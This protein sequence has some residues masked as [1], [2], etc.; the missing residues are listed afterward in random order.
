MT[1]NIRYKQA[2]KEALWAFG[3]TILY[4]V[5]WCICAYGLPNTKGFL[6]FPL[7]FEF[8][9]L[10]LPLLFTFI[11]YVCIKCVFRDIDLEG[12]QDEL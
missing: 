4:M 9:C 5:G 6:D 7:W 3:L 11:V 2:T 12:D 1:L 8:S 10:Y